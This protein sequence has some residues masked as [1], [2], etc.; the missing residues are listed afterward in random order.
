MHFG[1]MFNA[2]PD[3]LGDSLKGTAAFL[4]SDELKDAFRSFYILPSVFNSD[5]DRGFSVIS[6]DLNRA[7]ADSED[8][9]RLRSLGIDLTFDFILNHLSVLSPQFQ[10][11]LK[12]GDNSPY[13]HFFIDWNSFWEGRGELGEDGMIK[14]YPD[15]FNYGNLR[16][17]G[18]PVLTVRFPD[19]RDVPYWNTFYQQIIYPNV[20]AFDMMPLT[21]GQYH[22][23][24]RLSEY[25]NGQ[26]KDGKKPA[27]FD[28]SGFEKWREP[29]TDYL[30]DHAHYLGQMDVD[31]RSPVV[32]EW[33]DSVLRQLSSHGASMIRLDAFSRLHKAPART[34]FVNEPE[35]WDMLTRLR[36]MAESY[37]MEVLPEIHSAY[38]K[39][40]YKTLSDLAGMTYDYFLPG[41]VL[42][43]LDTGDS[44]YL[45]AW[46]EEIVRDGLRVVNM[47]GCHDG[48][49]MRDVRGL[50]PEERVDAIIERLTLRGGH[51]KIIHGI[52]DE[53][54][55]VAITYYSALGCDDRKMELA[56]AIQ[57][58]MPGKPQ[59][60]YM[61]LLAEPSDE[62]VLAR[63]PSA[64]TREVNR[65]NYTLAEAKACLQKPVVQK[66]LELLKLR[67]T[68]PAFSD[69][70]AVTV[71]RP[72]PDGIVLTWRA[73]EA[74]ASLRADLTALTYEI[75]VTC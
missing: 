62:E 16:K 25:I 21:D 26:L 35:T 42:D 48:I 39:K 6:Y 53:I 73:G 12:N 7:M 56:R 24:L 34:N 22:Q 28:W 59:V 72:S 5:L 55:Q 15:Q 33:Y 27:E 43:A 31:F 45:Y 18:L 29:A 46:A 49:P 13:R 71:E 19:G 2:Y 60:W 41:L 47:L 1:T 44:G 3:S 70:A 74:E 65:R 38:D 4:A 37:G 57:L 32:W 10:D 17:N 11:I 30:K 64:D 54:Y 63:D 68:H 66:Q 20:T 40:Y 36:K 52:K 69:G 14:P 58:F 75:S 61:D 9:D 51:K 23:A 50:L 8:L 67:N